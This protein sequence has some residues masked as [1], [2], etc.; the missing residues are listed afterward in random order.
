MNAEEGDQGHYECVAE[1]KVGTAYSNPAALYVRT[2]V[3]PPYFSIPPE[4]VYEIMPGSHI[5]L[6]C[7]AVG[8]P[9]PYVNWKRGHVELPT[10]ESAAPV[11]RNVL[12]LD[13]VRESTNYTCV[14]SSKLGTIEA[15]T[16]VV[17]KSLPRPPTNARISEITPT[18]VKLAWSYDINPEN[19]IY[20]VIQYK[21]K[22]S[23]QEYSEISGITTSF[24]VVSGM[25][26]YTEYE[27]FVIAVNAIGRGAPSAPVAATTGETMDDNGSRKA[28]S[29]PR[30]VQARPLSSSTILI[31]WDQPEEV[32]SQ[33]TG[34]KVYYTTHK[35]LPLSAWETQIVDNNKMTTVSDLQPQLIYTIRVEAFTTRGPGPPS[36]PVQVK[37]QQGVPGQPSD[38]QASAT[39]STTVQLTWKPAHSR[40]AITGYEVYWNDTFT[41]QEY[42][43]S[44][45]AVES[46]TLGELYPDTLY[47]VWVAGKSLRGE[48]AATPAIPVRTEQYGRCQLASCCFANFGIE[49]ERGGGGVKGEKDALP[50]RR[51]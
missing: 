24:Y 4:P 18:S 9:M 28:G 2:R 37:T 34:Y 40:E 29:A 50:L 20:Y 26:P 16:Q 23:N 25:T 41:N 17:V 42:R 1:N 49:R 44:I 13:D 21:P 22:S 32:G 7:V 47:F 27:F 8:S 30:N 3:V 43:R 15:N 39:S 35:E 14:A 11:G 10:P 33:V 6:T 48:G 36:A 45:P 38:L 19:I 31:Q 5:N 51:E 46:F 12:R